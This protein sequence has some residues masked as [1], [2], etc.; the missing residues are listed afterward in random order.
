MRPQDP[1]PLQGTLS[2]PARPPVRACPLSGPGP[3]P[4][5]RQARAGAS[6]PLVPR[7]PGWRRTR[8]GSDAAPAPQLPPRSA[9]AVRSASRPRARSDCFQNVPLVRTK[10][11]LLIAPEVP[12]R[13]KSGQLFPATIPQPLLSCGKSSLLSLPEGARVSPRASLS[14]APENGPP[15]SP[16]RASPAGLFPPPSRQAVTPQRRRPS[17]RHLEWR[18]SRGRRHAEKAG[19][20]GGRQRRG[21]GQRSR[22]SSARRRLR[23]HGERGQQRR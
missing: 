8:R 14:S 22:V 20:E 4:A 3:L 2:A 23:R 1:V 18:R 15:F 12:F 13:A 10:Q 19:K 6:R 21:R 17:S 7:V 9:G 5:P 16:Q 11:V